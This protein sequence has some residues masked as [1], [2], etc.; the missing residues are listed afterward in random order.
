MWNY[1]PF[2]LGRA[3]KELPFL[4]SL[5]ATTC[6]SLACGPEQDG[7]RKKEGSLAS[8]LKEDCII[9]YGCRYWLFP[10][11]FCCLVVVALSCCCCVFV[12]LVLLLV[13]VVGGGRFQTFRSIHDL[14]QC[15]KSVN[16]CFSPCK[17]A[18]ISYSAYRVEWKATPAVKTAV[19]NFLKFCGE[20][21]WSELM[22]QIM[23]TLAPTITTYQFL[24]ACSL[25]IFYESDVRGGDK[26]REI[27][28]QQI[29]SAVLMDGL[30][31]TRAN[32]RFHWW[33]PPF[34][35][36]SS[37]SKPLSLRFAMQ[38]SLIDRCTSTASILPLL[39]IHHVITILIYYL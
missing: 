8:E 34:A 36:R 37:L 30:P 13:L 16:T 2:I 27:E 11:R 21:E 22:K 14:Y 9:Y 23:A 38:S 1:I 33:S 24:T 29:E 7:L 6:A 18:G 25:N 12:S 17:W 26:A 39:P 5:P 10:S 31:P 19:A 15:C 20:K 32:S 3:S 4:Y 35:I 28:P